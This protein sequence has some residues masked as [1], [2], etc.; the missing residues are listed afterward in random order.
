MRDAFA[1]RWDP[2]R[3]YFGVNPR[4]RWRAE[5]A[6]RHPSDVRV[7]YVW[8]WTI[9]LGY[10]A[11][12]AVGFRLL[13]AWAGGTVWLSLKALFPVGGVGVLVWLM[14]FR[15]PA[16]RRWKLG[17]LADRWGVRPMRCFACDY[18]VSQSIG[19]TCPECGARVPGGSGRAAPG[20]RKLKSL[21]AE[22]QRIGARRGRRRLRRWL[23]W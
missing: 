16:K 5:A 22:K 10:V 2:V 19:E 9:V 7:T 21:N 1:K 3:F 17:V 12:S 11:A 6:L 15:L 4:F 18:D 23:G 14:W 8:E 13:D 20:R